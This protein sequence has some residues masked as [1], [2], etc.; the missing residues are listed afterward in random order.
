MATE[1]V[2]TPISSST[3]QHNDSFITVPSDTRIETP[4]YASA[5]LTWAVG[6]KTIDYRATAAHI[7]VRSDTCALIAKMFSV[8]Y[9]A[10]EEGMPQKN[11]PVTFAFNG[12]PGCASIPINFGGIG[13]RRV[14]T[15]GMDHLGRPT[16]LDNPHT[17]LKESDLV[18]LDAP[19]VGWS[20]FAEGAEAEKCFG[21]DGDADA[22]ARAIMQW[23]EDNDRWQSPVFLFGESYGTLRNA[24]LMGILG[25]RGVFV[26]G[27]V[28][29]SSIFDWTQT[30]PGDDLYYLGMMPTFAATAQYFGKAGMGIQEDLWFEQ[31]MGFTEDVYA[32]AL[33]KGDRLTTQAMEK[34]AAEMSEFIGISPE[35]I[36]KK[37]LRLSLHDF[38]HELLADEGQVIGRLDTR[39]VSDASHPAQGNHGDADSDPAGDAMDSAWTM[40][41]REFMSNT[42]GYRGPATYLSNNYQAIGTKWN[43]AHS[44]PGTSLKVGAPNVSFDIATALKRNP[45]I[46]MAFLGG[47]YDCA[48][49]LWNTYHDMSCMFLSENIKKNIYW[50]RYGCGHMAYTD[51]PTLEQMDKD[52]HQFYKAALED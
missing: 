15:H 43:W 33:L 50:Y 35:F 1:V 45:N 3:T 32:P 7:D 13:P 11:R 46:H 20:S 29:L 41:F 2:Q 5:D 25:E 39:F 21:V 8:S 6:S 10:L 49:T 12:G 17:L 47:R 52:L 14:E 30:L 38:R 22:F 48:T 19:G 31:A 51:V 36:M 40:A 44:V 23:L 18:F 9:I 24:V 42:L 27:V 28:M 4:K 34:V 37:S 16:T 26:S